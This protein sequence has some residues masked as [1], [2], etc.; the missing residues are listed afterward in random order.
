[1]WF[2]LAKVPEISGT[3]AGGQIGLDVAVHQGR[4]SE[5]NTCV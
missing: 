3:D 5:L 4:G 1:M 2:L